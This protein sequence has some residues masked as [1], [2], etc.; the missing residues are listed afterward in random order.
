M[1]TRSDSKSNSP[2]RRLDRRKRS[3]LALT[4]KSDGSIDAVVMGA[5]SERD[6]EL[7]AAAIAKLRAAMTEN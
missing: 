6:R 5:V 1:S 7:L 4:I 2:I 3:S